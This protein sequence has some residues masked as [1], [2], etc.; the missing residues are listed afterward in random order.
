MLTRMDSSPP[1]RSSQSGSHSPTIF[2]S[3]S[4]DSEADTGPECNQIPSPPIGVTLEEPTTL[5]RRLQTAQTPSTASTSSSSTQVHAQ[6]FKGTTA[7]Q[8]EQPINMTTSSSTTLMTSSVS[9]AMPSIKGQERTILE[10]EDASGEQLGRSDSVESCPVVSS[11]ASFREKND[12]INLNEEVSSTSGIASHSETVPPPLGSL[13]TESQPNTEVLSCEPHSRDQVQ[14]AGEDGGDFE[15]SVYAED[16]GASLGGDGTPTSDTGRGGPVKDVH[17][18][19]TRVDKLKKKKEESRRR[20]S[21]RDKQRKRHHKHSHQR[22]RS[23][24]RSRSKTYRSHRH[25]S[26]SES[27]YHRRESSHKERKSSHRFRSSSRSSSYHN[28]SDDETPKRKRKSKDKIERIRRKQ[29]EDRKERRERAD[30][31]GRRQERVRSRSLRPALSKHHHDSHDYDHR[32]SPS[33]YERRHRSRLYSEESWSKHS[34]FSH[35]SEKHSTS[36][37]H[38]MQK[39]KTKRKRRE[40]TSVE[41]T[42]ESDEEMQKSEMTGKTKKLTEELSEVDRQIQDNKKELLKS[43]LRKE[44]LEL[45]QRNLHGEGSLTSGGVLSAAVGCVLEDKH[46]VAKKTTGEMERELELLNRAIVDGKKRLLRVMK[47]VEED[48]L[49]DD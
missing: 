4:S 49:D 21:E 10:L 24:S 12:S 1:L 43:M 40:Q 26:P 23:R 35:V 27:R 18:K 13:T 42:D 17:G 28:S 47:K 25:R 16:G 39:R 41:R 46:D 48:Q 11:S 8:R 9:S 6:N 20:S 33:R 22:S 29:D 5:D 32:K 19:S 30:Y 2:I 31:K 14:E 36:N 3:D 34:Q 38:D 45:L 37:I 44:R 15:I 7:E